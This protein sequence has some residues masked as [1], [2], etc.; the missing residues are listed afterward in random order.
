MLGKSW[1]ISSTAIR[2]SVSKM[3]VFQLQ[4]DVAK[5]SLCLKKF[6]SRRTFNGEFEEANFFSRAATHVA[7]VVISLHMIHLSQETRT[8]RMLI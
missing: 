1:L 8:S 2:T 6:S 7:A 4:I 5:A 3:G